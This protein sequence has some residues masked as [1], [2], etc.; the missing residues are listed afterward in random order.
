MHFA[1]FAIAAVISSRSNW[2]G[3][4]CPAFRIYSAFREIR[5]SSIDPR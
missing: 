5:N 1:F 4:R 2:K 3:G